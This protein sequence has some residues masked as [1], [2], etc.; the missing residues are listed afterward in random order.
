[1]S[2]QPAWQLSFEFSG[3]PLVIVEPAD[4][5]FMGDA[6]LLPL[7]RRVPARFARGLNDS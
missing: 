2:L 7:F 1:M 5:L 4:E 6:G 3:L